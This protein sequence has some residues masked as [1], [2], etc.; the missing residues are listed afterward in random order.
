MGMENNPIRPGSYGPIGGPPSAR[1]TWQIGSH[2]SHGKKFLIHIMVVVSWPAGRP[3]GEAIGAGHRRRG[4]AAG[5][6][7]SRLRRRGAS[8]WGAGAKAAVFYGGGEQR[9]GSPVVVEAKHAGES[10]RRSEQNIGVC[11]S[12]H[13]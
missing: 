12:R 3:A 9:D 1:D 4:R 10:R 13:S 7:H 6:D 8:C 2:S 5:I 11:S